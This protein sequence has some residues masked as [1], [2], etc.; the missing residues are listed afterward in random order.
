VFGNSHHGTF[1]RRK[2]ENQVVAKI[3]ASV[4]ASLMTT[5]LLIGPA[6]PATAGG[7]GCVA[8]S[9]NLWANQCI[10]VDGSGTRVNN[11]RITYTN[12]GANICNRKS[13]AWGTRT[14]GWHYY[15][16]SVF[17]GVAS[18]QRPVLRSLPTPTSGSARGCGDT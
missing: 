14:N 13:G 17:Y 8:A 1:D 11:V 18:L 4:A 5:G 12:P 15:K 6:V 16:E 10:F 3:L 2:N 7:T 9:G